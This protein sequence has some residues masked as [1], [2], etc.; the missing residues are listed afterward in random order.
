VSQQLAVAA[1]PAFHLPASRRFHTLPRH[2]RDLT[3][4]VRR[5]VERLAYWESSI[6]EVDESSASLI[7]E[8]AV[9]VL[10]QQ[11]DRALN[12][13]IEVARAMMQHPDP[14][15]CWADESVLT[16][17]GGILALIRKG[18]DRPDVI[19]FSLDNLSSGES[20]RP[21][22]RT[23]RIFFVDGSFASVSYGVGIPLAGRDLTSA[24]EASIESVC[25]RMEHPKPEYRQTEDVAL[26][27][28]G[29]AL[30]I[31]R[32]SPAGPVVHRF[33][34]AATDSIT[35]PRKQEGGRNV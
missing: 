16:Y 15:L 2:L 20:V 13:M 35:R 23:P 14:T 11:V 26:T 8:V 22:A 29:R 6:F 34:P 30:A 5:D 17:R 33:G 9:P 27:Y 7:D 21:G 31:V 32:V 19:R 28:R 18:T 10:G 25:I 1:S 4:E 12:Y 3:P 24:M